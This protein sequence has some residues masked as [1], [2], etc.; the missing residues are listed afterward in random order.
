[1]GEKKR[2]Q[3]FCRRKKALVVPWQVGGSSLRASEIRLHADDRSMRIRGSVRHLE[4]GKVAC[5]VDTDVQE[6]DAQAIGTRQV[7]R[8]YDVWIIIHFQLLY[9]IL[10]P[11]IRFRLR[12]PIKVIAA[13]SAI[14]I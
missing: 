9:T 5:R 2:A 1:M 11:T 12:S 10:P 3:L 8:F 6:S 4:L 14:S 7:N 13:V